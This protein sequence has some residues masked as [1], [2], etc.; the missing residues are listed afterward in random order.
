ML[1]SDSPKY[2]E[3]LF[4][5]LFI[6]RLQRKTKCYS[7]DGKLSI[8]FF[9]NKIYLFVVFNS[10]MTTALNIH[11]EPDRLKKDMYK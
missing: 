10:I 11:E 2:I 7:L 4:L 9:K 6:V 5:K 1:T 3:M 8:S